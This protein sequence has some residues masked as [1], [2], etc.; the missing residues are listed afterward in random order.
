MRRIETTAFL[1]TQLDFI[2][3]FYGL[4]FIL[5]GAVCFAIRKS[6]PRGM[7]WSMLGL[8]GFLHGG[9]EWL[10]LLALIFGDSPAFAWSRLGLMMASYV[11]LMEFARQEAV[12][13]GIK[14]PGQWIHLL[15]ILIVIAG[16]L[17]LGLAE[18]NALA[19]YSMGFVGAMGTAFI[20]VLH[21]KALSGSERALALSA[22]IG[23]ALYGL[24]AG[25]IVPT[26]RSGRQA[27]TTTLA[28]RH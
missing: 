6:N 27:S 19:R 23:F 24:A 18:A 17:A 13:L 7:P 28:S 16:S 26:A 3:F 12:R 5:L 21:A 10:D 2:F 9:L 11:F 20:I 25:L 14:M 1:S 4:A 22:A 15:P 8:F